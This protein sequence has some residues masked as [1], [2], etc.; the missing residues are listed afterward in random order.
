MDQEKVQGKS[1]YGKRPLWQWVLIYVIVGGAVY[2]AVYYFMM[3]KS[4][5]VY[6]KASTQSAPAT[7][8]MQS[9]SSGYKW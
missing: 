5:N 9:Q 8:Q 2:A 3:P 6:G 4:G 1:K 7:T